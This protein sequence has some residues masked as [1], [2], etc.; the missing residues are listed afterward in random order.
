MIKTI[1][2]YKQ[3]ERVLGS[4]IINRSK[5]LNVEGQPKRIFSQTLLLIPSP[6]AAAL[7]ISNSEVY[8]DKKTKEEFVAF[9]ISET[10]PRNKVRVPAPP[11][12]PMMG[13][14]GIV[15]QCIWH[16]DLGW[17]VIQ[18]PK[19]PSEQ[20]QD[21]MK[22]A[23][24]RIVRFA[25]HSKFHY[26]QVI[27]QL[28]LVNE[29]ARL[30]EI[31]A[32]LRSKGTSTDHMSFLQGVPAT[33][34]DSTRLL[35]FTGGKSYVPLT[36]KDESGKCMAFV[37]NNQ[38]DSSIHSTIPLNPSTPAKPTT[39]VCRISKPFREKFAQEYDAKEPK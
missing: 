1:A 34:E 24:V 5:T 37:P 28:D 35:C 30:G 9:V 23:Q 20:E 22:Q 21:I 15:G 26:H 36:P 31:H 19:V 33:E 3:L 32:I 39:E 10:T 6:K 8:I 4:K 29:N 27:S 25:L 2:A 11:P 13:L 16:K 12:N 14:R 17:G 18:G 38:D 7:S